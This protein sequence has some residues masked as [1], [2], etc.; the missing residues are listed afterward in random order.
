M[1][2]GFFGWWLFRGIVSPLEPKTQYSRSMSAR[3]IVTIPYEPVQY[4]RRRSNSFTS[5]TLSS[6]PT[7]YSDTSSVNLL[8]GRQGPFAYRSKANSI[9]GIEDD[10]RTELPRARLCSKERIRVLKNTVKLR[11]ILGEAL[12]E[13]VVKQCVIAPK[14]RNACHH[15]SESTVLSDCST[16]TE[17]D[18]LRYHNDIKF[19]QTNCGGLSAPDGLQDN[20]V[21]SAA[22]KRATVKRSAKL[23]SLLGER[24]YAYHPIC[25]S[26][27]LHLN[28]LERSDDGLYSKISLRGEEPVAEPSYI[29]KRVKNALKKLA[30]PGVADEEKESVLWLR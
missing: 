24:I 26:A 17:S 8:P 4:S 27:Q 14:K 28:A 6:R 9:L 19:E 20:S 7:L 16:E 5:A 15:C 12:D 13:E 22:E 29:E 23:F 25:P 10:I 30:V 3:S 11:R 1:P 18:V 2:T 21:Y